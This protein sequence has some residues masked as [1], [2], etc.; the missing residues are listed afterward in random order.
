L[1]LLKNQPISWRKVLFEKVVVAQLV[2]KTSVKP[3]GLLEYSQGALITLCPEPDESS[4][5]FHTL[6]L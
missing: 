1:W 4:P 2:L 6:S 5:L 3:E